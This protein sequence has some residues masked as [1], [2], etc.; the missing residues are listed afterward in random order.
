VLVV[1]PAD[2]GFVPISLHEPVVRVTLPHPRAAD[3]VLDVRQAPA[4]S[5]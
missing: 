5:P 1:A 3:G 2:V 4:Q